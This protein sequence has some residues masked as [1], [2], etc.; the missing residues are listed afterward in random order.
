[1]QKLQVLI[2]NAVL[3]VLCTVHVD[4]GVGYSCISGSAESA[5]PRYE[6]E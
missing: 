5:V 6:H 4:C 3:R 2:E 1:M